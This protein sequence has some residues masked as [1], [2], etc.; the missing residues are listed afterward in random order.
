MEDH[1]GRGS[2]R[3]GEGGSVRE[4]WGRED[5]NMHLDPSAATATLLL[6]EL[7]RHGTDWSVHDATAAHRHTVKP[8][9]RT[10]AA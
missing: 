4:V 2:V 6:L 10:S 3:V 9:I 1:E 7:R 8:T 5:P